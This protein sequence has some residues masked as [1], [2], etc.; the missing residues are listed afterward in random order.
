MHHLLHSDFKRV[1]IPELA[2]VPYHSF[3]VIQTLHRNRIVNECSSWEDWQASNKAILFIPMALELAMM[4]G[5]RP[6]ALIGNKYFLR[7]AMQ[8]LGRAVPFIAVSL[9]TVHQI[10]VDL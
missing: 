4:C 6:T 10:V 8:C 3:I 7:Q 2:S 1:N 9:G 5:L